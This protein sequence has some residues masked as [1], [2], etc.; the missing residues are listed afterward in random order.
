MKPARRVAAVL[1]ALYIVGGPAFQQLG[2]SQILPFQT[3]RMYSTVGLWAPYG[4]FQVHGQD[5]DDVI[6]EV[7]ITR[8]MGLDSIRGLQPYP[9]SGGINRDFRSLEEYRS[10]AAPL[11]ASLAADENLR[12]EG[13][14]AVPDRWYEFSLTEEQLC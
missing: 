13:R 6:R 8:A 12:F 7:P 11:C 4:A 10:V 5:S 14:I 1:L 2:I 3:W 9:G